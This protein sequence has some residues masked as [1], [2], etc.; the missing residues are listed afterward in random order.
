VLVAA[1]NRP[2]GLTVEPMNFPYGVITRSPSG[3]MIWSSETWIPVAYW[4]PTWF[5]PNTVVSADAIP[6]PATTTA[7]IP[8]A[9]MRSRR[10]RP[11]RSL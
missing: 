3:L 8:T 1:R 4:V 7:A 5:W 10:P 11:P 6:A 2:F 9:A